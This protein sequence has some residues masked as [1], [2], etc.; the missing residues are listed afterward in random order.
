M[1]ANHGVVENLPG[2]IT[3]LSHSYA[4]ETEEEVIVPIISEWEITTP[5][6]RDLIRGLLLVAILTDF[7]TGATE[8]PVR[9]TF[10]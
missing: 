5:L 10:L 3:Q 1:V 6:P 8:V 2:L 4:P 7:A 9:L